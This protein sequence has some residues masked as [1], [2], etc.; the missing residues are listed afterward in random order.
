MIC[1][2]FNVINSKSTCFQ[3]WPAF[4]GHFYSIP[5][6]KFDCVLENVGFIIQDPKVA[7]EDI[8]ASELYPCVTF[9]SSSPGEK[10]WNANL[11]YS[12]GEVPAKKKPQ[13]LQYP[14]VESESWFAVLKFYVVSRKFWEIQTMQTKTYIKNAKSL[15]IRVLVIKGLFSSNWGYNLCSYWVVYKTSACIFFV[16]LAKLKIFSIH[17]N[18]Y[19]M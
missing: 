16:S 17:R 10:V 4:K 13:T 15:E 2:C 1:K 9:Y 11:W 5:W 14:N 19:T 7:F 6:G 18:I 8:D 12:G 3:Q